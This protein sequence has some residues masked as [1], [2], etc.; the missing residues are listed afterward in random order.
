MQC[1]RQPQ[2]TAQSPILRG[3]LPEGLS[4]F[5][6]DVLSPEAARVRQPRE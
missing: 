6:A 1:L 2:V 3:L 4:D 5:K